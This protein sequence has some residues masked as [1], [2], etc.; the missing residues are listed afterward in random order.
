M[1]CLTQ[2]TGESN[3]RGFTACDSCAVK[4]KPQTNMRRMLFRCRLRLRLSLSLQRLERISQYSTICLFFMLFHLCFKS[5]LKSRQSFE[6][7]TGMIRSIMLFRRPLYFLV[8]PI[9]HKTSLHPNYY[10]YIHAEG[11]RAGLS[12]SKRLI[13]PLSFFPLQSFIFTIWSIRV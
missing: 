1:L 5:W 9:K 7:G 8:H 10:C 4:E 3:W 2:I 13:R 12:E 11:Y 6:R